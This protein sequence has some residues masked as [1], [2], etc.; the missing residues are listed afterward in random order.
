MEADL[1]LGTLE[2]DSL[3]PYVPKSIKVLSSLLTRCELVRFHKRGSDGMVSP[4][5]LCDFIE[6]AHSHNKCS[7]AVCRSAHGGISSGGGSKLQG[8]CILYA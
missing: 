2:S 7:Q 3:F 4:H 5:S 1:P 6:W 8:P